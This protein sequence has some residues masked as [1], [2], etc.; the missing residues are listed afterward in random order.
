MPLFG[1][2]LRLLF[3]FSGFSRSGRTTCTVIGFRRLS[4]GE[5]EAWGRTNR[6]SDHGNACRGHGLWVLHSWR[7]S[8]LLSLHSEELGTHISEFSLVLGLQK[9]LVLCKGLSFG[10]QPIQRLLVL[11]QLGHELGLTVLC[12]SS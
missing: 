1:L 12:F 10:M 8:V 3:M 11:E 7:G 2:S 9:G 4:F 5:L 6:L